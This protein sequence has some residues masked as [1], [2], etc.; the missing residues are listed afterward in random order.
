MR[1]PT[2]TYGLLL[3]LATACL[4]SRVAPQPRVFVIGD[5]ISLQ[6]GPYLRE[7]LAGVATYDR[8]RDDGQAMQDLDR[9][10]GANGGDS[11]MVLAYLR[12]LRAGPGLAA[13]Y[14]L[15]NCG[16][17]D[18]KTNPGSGRPQVPLRE[19][20]RNLD[21]ILR[22]ARALDV[23]PIWM[24]TTPVVDSIH[25]RS[26]GGFHRFAADVARYNAA[27]DS[28]M[29]V[30]GVPAVDL[31]TLSQSFGPGAFKDHVHYREEFRARQG[32]YLGGWLVGYLR[33]TR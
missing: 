18:I 24:R 1:I 29:A 2:P 27:A 21:T 33:A 31:W 3:V 19:Y 30:H 15:L 5:S 26:M 20:A 28:V 25:N 10:V 17:H 6:Y 7:A 23:K 22:V 9:P 11:R 16:L 13:D 4:A 12:E 14:L 8:K 32:A